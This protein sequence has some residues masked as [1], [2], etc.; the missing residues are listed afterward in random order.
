MKHGFVSSITGRK[1]RFKLVNVLY[2]KY[3]VTNLMNADYQMFNN[4][5]NKIPGLKE[6]Y[7]S[8]KDLKR[9][10]KNEFNLAKNFRIQ[11]LAASVVNASMIKIRERLLEEKLDAKICLQVHDSITVHVRKDQ[12]QR[13]Y[14]IVQ[15]SMENNWVSEMMDIPLVAEPAIGNNL[16]ED[17]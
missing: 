14:E 11:S 16:S 5:W 4:M 1:K 10:I 8:P 9:A 15:D 7:E 6:Q 2:N 12:A 13:V 17:K 3:K